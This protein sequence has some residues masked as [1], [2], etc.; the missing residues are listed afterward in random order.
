M[1][2]LK[3]SLK[4]FLLKKGFK[5]SK[6]NNSV[7]Q[8]DN[9]FL[10]VYSKFNQKSFIAFDVGANSGDTVKKI[11]KVI[12][13]ASIHCFEP[14]KIVFKYLIENVKKFPDVICNQI[15]LGSEVSISQF[16]E[17]SWNVLNSF[18]KRKYTTSQIVET[19]PVE[20]T[21]L[22]LYFE[23]HKLRYINILKTDTEGFEL[24]VLKGA[25][26]IF[27][28]N[29][30]QFV[31]V[32]ALFDENFIGQASFGDIYNYL[33]MNGFSIVRFYDFTYTND[34]LVSRSDVL[35]YNKNFL[36]N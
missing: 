8:H 10:A 19:Y 14:S 6:I 31:L 23:K 15:A 21:K 7:I 13:N 34:N 4:N 25:E 11:K 26:S 30:V 1:I 18:F 2:Q 29:K 36:F 20:I 16:N 12:P 3:K 17:Y 5:I 28:Q 35:F 22:D 9:P 27:K 32:E 24:N 33:I